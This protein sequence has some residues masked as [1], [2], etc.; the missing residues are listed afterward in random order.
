M[1]EKHTLPMTPRAA[2]RRYG[3]GWI[4]VEL[5][6]VFVGVYGAFLLN[7]HQSNQR[8][9]ARAQQ[10]HCAL[11]QEVANIVEGARL[12]LPL[13]Q[14]AFDGWL[15]EYQRGERPAPLFL[16]RGGVHRPSTA[17]WEASLTSGATETLDIPLLYR[18]SE[19]YHT[20]QV[21]LTKNEE[22]YAFACSHILPVGDSGVAAFYQDDTPNLKGHFREYMETQGKI[23]RTGDIVLQDGEYILE[24]LL[25]LCEEQLV[26]TSAEGDS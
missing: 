9:A 10:I 20:L 13:M 11:A 2:R 4:I 15:A 3:Y 1:S 12:N 5:L 25:A 22:L 7:E 23:I 19:F 21:V 26:D 24:K 8:A 17:I 6:V 18:L 14:A 16:G